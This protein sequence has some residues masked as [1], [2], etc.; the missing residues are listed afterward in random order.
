M[1]APDQTISS[2]KTEIINALHRIVPI[3][4][5][6]GL[7][8]FNFEQ[9][10]VGEVLKAYEYVDDC[11]IELRDIYPL[12]YNNELVALANQLSTGAYYISTDLAR[13]MNKLDASNAAMVYDAN[14]CWLYNGTEFIQI[15]ESA[16][17]MIWRGSISNERAITIPKVSNIQL[18][19][20]NVSS[21]LEY[22]DSQ[23]NTYKTG[24]HAVTLY[25][26]DLNNEFIKVM[27]PTVDP[28]A[29]QPTYGACYGFKEGNTYIYYNELASIEN[30]L[31]SA[32]CQ[33]W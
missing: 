1:T 11:F 13:K 12:F 27:D 18:C 16:Q 32:I 4:T 20:M 26:I 2:Y 6:I 22:Y 25:A 9:L 7:G 10:R 24:G 28:S 30:T 21:H 23:K 19:N 14:S 17:E 31:V 29:F 3:K 15:T 5:D 8:D 33:Y